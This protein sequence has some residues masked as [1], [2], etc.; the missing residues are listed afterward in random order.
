MLLE[1]LARLKVS[2][3]VLPVNL[4]SGLFKM[5]IKIYD[6]MGDVISMQYG[7]SIAHHSALN[8]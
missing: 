3:G 5:L 7:G 1:Q 8:N 2:S 6:T 4:K